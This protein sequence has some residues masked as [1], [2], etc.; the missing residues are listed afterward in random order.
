M[1]GAI[2]HAPIRILADNKKNKKQVK[3]FFT[4]NGEE[5]WGR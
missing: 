1:H 5:K 2:T 3:W 4:F